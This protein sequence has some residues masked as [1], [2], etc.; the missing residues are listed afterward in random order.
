M[1]E[2]EV[3]KNKCLICHKEYNI[4]KIKDDGINWK[5]KKIK[6]PTEEI[7]D[8]GCPFCEKEN[9]SIN[10]EDK[11]KE[12]MGRYNLKHFPVQVT[13]IAGY[14]NNKYPKNYLYSSPE[15]INVGLYKNPYTKNF[16]YVEIDSKNLLLSMSE[17]ELINFSKNQTKKPFKCVNIYNSQ[18]NLIKLRLK[19]YID[20]N[21]FDKAKFL[22]KK[23]DFLNNHDF[24]DYL[25]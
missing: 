16:G 19:D 1:K 5:G 24:F 15:P 6:E 21:Q 14:N 25:N 18:V 4:F 12:I 9:Q 2:K 22:L 13:F 11:V 7:I 8:K 20:L 23:L 10:K 3:I 17:E